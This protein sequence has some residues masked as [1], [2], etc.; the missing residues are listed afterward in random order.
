MG[1][2]LESN[3]V[4]GYQ[5]YMVLLTPLI[6]SS[7]SLVLHFVADSLMMEFTTRLCALL[8]LLPALAER[9]P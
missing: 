3:V 9:R 6:V 2:I 8:T 5:A 1:S 7:L 4:C